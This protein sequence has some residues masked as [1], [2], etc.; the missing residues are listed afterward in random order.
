MTD[1]HTQPH[2]PTAALLSIDVQRDVLSGG[3][4]AFAS[5][6]GLLRN[7]ACVVEAFRAADRPSALDAH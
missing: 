2:F 1:H 6:E 7:M 4:M 5:P 3:P